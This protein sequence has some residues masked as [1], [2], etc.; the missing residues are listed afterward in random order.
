MNY[1]TPYHE[2]KDSFF[3]SVDSQLLFSNIFLK[4]L[5]L[6]GVSVYANEL[7]VCRKYPQCTKLCFFA[8]FDIFRRMCESHRWLLRLQIQQQ[9][10]RMGAFAFFST[11]SIFI[12]PLPHGAQIPKL[13]CKKDISQMIFISQL[14]CKYLQGRKLMS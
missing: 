14:E 5:M 4:N 3:V 8:S 9:A 7:V 6:P 13:D 1:R 11:V 12:S 2:E 10:S